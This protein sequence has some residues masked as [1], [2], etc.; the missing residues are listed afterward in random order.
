MSPL[1]PTVVTDAVKEQVKKGVTDS[2]S[3]DLAELLSYWHI[4]RVRGVLLMPS[5]HGSSN[6]LSIRLKMLARH[7]ACDCLLK[8]D[9]TLHTTKR[10]G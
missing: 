6:E 3:P 2:R 7:R 10:K 4:W 1:P 8:G 9:N 5:Y